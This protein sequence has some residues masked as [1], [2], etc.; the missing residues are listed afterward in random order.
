MTEPDKAALLAC[1]LECAHAERQL[2]GDIT[3]RDWVHV[4]GLGYHAACRRLA[5]MVE[6]GI[7]TEHL[8][9]LE[10]GR[11]GKVYRPAKT[12]A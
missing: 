4:S 3:V 8:V 1:M 12:G 5:E 11:K 2:P 9:I 10:N 6:A 7:L